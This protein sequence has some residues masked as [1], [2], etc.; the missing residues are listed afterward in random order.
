MKKLFYFF[1]FAIL[2]FN[3]SCFDTCEDLGYTFKD[4]QVKSYFADNNKINVFIDFEAVKDLPI[5]YFTK[6]KIDHSKEIDS[7]Y[8]VSNTR[9]IV[10]IFLE[11]IYEESAK[12]DLEIMLEL[13]DRE[14]YI[15]CSHFSKYKY[16]NN[17]SFSIKKETYTV[18][19]IIIDDWKETVIEDKK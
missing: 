4:L 9:M 18:Y 1:V 19:E 16:F 11:G 14:D 6:A 2:I 8:F 7:V 13:P 10:E 5:E 12:K 15:K 17:V 3:T